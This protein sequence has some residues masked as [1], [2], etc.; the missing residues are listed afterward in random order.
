MN[1]IRKFDQPLILKNSQSTK[2]QVQNDNNFL[3]VDNAEPFSDKKVRKTLI[4]AEVN[5]QTI[6]GPLDQN[7]DEISFDSQFS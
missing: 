4:Q 2:K 5:E 1:E 3:D 7:I 6:D